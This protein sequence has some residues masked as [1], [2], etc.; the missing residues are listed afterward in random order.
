MTFSMQKDNG[1]GLPE[2]VKSLK[3][4]ILYFKQHLDTLQRHIN[5]TQKSLWEAEDQ[6]KAVC[7][8]NGHKYESGRSALLGS[9]DD[10]SI[11]YVCAIC[12]EEY[13][14]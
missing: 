13:L 4:Q 9:K 12:Q 8:K 14:G 5:V 6:L 10:E 11:I 7:E 3:D 1:E 2:N